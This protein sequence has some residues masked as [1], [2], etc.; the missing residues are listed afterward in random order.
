VKLLQNMTLTCTA[1]IGV[2]R[3]GA[4]SLPCG[5]V[6]HAYLELLYSPCCLRAFF[7]AGFHRATVFFKC[8][9]CFAQTAFC[10]FTSQSLPLCLHTRSE[11]VG[12]LKTIRDQHTESKQHLRVS[13]DAN[14]VS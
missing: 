10:T 6:Q 3:S 14:L 12:S 1:V 13:G 5:M 4:I 2:S 11:Y 8:L 7:S 9:V